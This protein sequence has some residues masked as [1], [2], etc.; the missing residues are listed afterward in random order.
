MYNY[1]PTS[2]FASKTLRSMD[3]RKGAMIH[4][5]AIRKS[6]KIMEDNASSHASQ[7]DSRVF[8]EKNPP[9]TMID[10]DSDGD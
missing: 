5:Q 9:S 1:K 10:D 2:G 8:S 3:Q 7:M 6:E 4:E